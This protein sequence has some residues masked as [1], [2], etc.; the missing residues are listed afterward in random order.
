MRTPTPNRPA[1]LLPRWL[2]LP[3]QRRGKRRLYGQDANGRITATQ[4]LP[5]AY[6]LG[7]LIIA[8]IT[9]A[10]INMAFVMAPGLPINPDIAQR[11]AYLA[12]HAARWQLGWLS[13][14]ASAIGL[15]TFCVLLAQHI[16]HD[17][18][19]TLG[20]TLVAIGIAPDISAEMLYAFVLPG[21]QNIEHAL[22]LDR[23]A[24]LLTG[25]VGNGFYCLGGLLLN[26]ALFRNPDLSRYMLNFGLP[27]WCIGLL[28]SVSTALQHMPAASLFT[29]IA[30][31]WN[32]LWML[33][34]TQTALRHPTGVT[35]HA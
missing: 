17:L 35:R 30:M 5:V 32:V 3:H 22:L 24:M 23:I 19:R 20:V 18:S 10:C 9:L 28:I 25:F 14:M 6:L 21:T 16:P 1:D 7:L 11:L 4:P 8:M 13:W 27:S 34:F 15:L 29:A 31:V 26:I 33:W 2:G 12:E